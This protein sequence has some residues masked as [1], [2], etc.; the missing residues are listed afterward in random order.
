MADSLRVRLL[1][2]YAAILM[3]VIGMVGVAVCVVTWRSRLATVDAE[4]HARA[5]VVSTAVERRAGGA[6]D[7]EL[8][9]DATAYF[10]ES[11][12]RPYYAVWG[13]DGR[14]IDRTDPDVTASGPPEARARTR[15][16]HREVVISSRG[17]TVLVGR[18]IGDVRREILVARRHDRDGGARRRRSVARRRLVYRRPRA[19]PRPAH[20]R[21]G[22][23]DGGGRSQRA[24]RGRADRHR[25]R[26][27][28]F[29]AESCVR[30]AARIGRTPAAVHGRC[31]ARAQ[32]SGRDDDG[33]ARVGA[34]AR[35]IHG[36]L[37]RVA[38]YLPSSGRTHAVAHRRPADARA[39]RQRRASRAA[40]DL[41]GSTSS[42]TK[43]SICCGPSRSS[44][45]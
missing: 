33:R 26:S 32:N 21:D 14:L 37:Q 29:G 39:R 35:A 43:P 44:G 45:T 38:R 15:G 12:T 9:S 19:G 4:L 2:W 36:R 13:G 16:S 28:R 7:V 31:L 24:D 20:Q 23:A 11:P 40:S 17:L 6:F 25:A 34:P 18:D 8:P 27:G 41:F 30:P 5:A 1:L 22:A 3:L 42:S 10:Q